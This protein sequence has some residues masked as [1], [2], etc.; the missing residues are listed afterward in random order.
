MAYNFSMSEQELVKGI[1]EIPSTYGAFASLVQ[2]LGIAGVEY[3]IIN[4]KGEYLQNILEQLPEKYRVF[5]RQWAT[6]ANVA[7][8]FDKE[9]QN[10]HFSGRKGAAILKAR[11][12]EWKRENPEVLTPEDEKMLENLASFAAGVLSAVQWDSQLKKEQKEK[13]DA[14]AVTVDDLK[15]SIERLKKKAEKAGIELSAFDIGNPVVVTEELPKDVQD[16]VNLLMPHAGN[17]PVMES[18]VVAVTLA[19]HEA[20]KT[21]Q[22]TKA[23]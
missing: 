23:A 5:F 13:R 16:V 12:V 11:G 6:Q 1:S 9:K 15:K 20:T 22:E 2:R 19:L 8:V 14:K 21:S 4:R 18:L 17:K 3:A 7:L 10:V